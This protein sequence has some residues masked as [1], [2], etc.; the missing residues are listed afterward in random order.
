MGQQEQ[1]AGERE[2]K[3]R[4]G[5]GDYVVILCR[6]RVDSIY[7]HAYS[8]LSVAVLWWRPNFWVTNFWLFYRG[9]AAPDGPPEVLYPS[10]VSLCCKAAVGPPWLDTY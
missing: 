7:T 10:L 8:V 5:Q 1:N 6:P 9:E 3:L 2:Y 4:K